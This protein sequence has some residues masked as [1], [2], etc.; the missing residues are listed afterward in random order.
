MPSF[1]IHL[2]IR[3]LPNKSNGGIQT[4]GLVKKHFRK[5]GNV[6]KSIFSLG[7]VGFNENITSRGYPFSEDDSLTPSN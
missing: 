4:V 6:S 7:K 1:K 3:E 5:V 2:C